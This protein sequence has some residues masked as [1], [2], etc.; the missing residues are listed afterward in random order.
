[1]LLSDLGFLCTDT[2]LL[3]ALSG[4]HSGQ[5]SLC[6]LE[7][8][9]ELDDFVAFLAELKIFVVGGFERGSDLLRR[10]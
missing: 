2:F 5:V 6:L 1:M 7:H 9:L 8:V 4:L 3:R 10:F